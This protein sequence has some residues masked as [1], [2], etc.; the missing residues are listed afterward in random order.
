[1]LFACDFGLPAG[2]FDVE[3]ADGSTE[4]CERVFERLVGGDGVLFGTIIAAY[5]LFEQF[6]V[7]GECLVEYIVFELLLRFLRTQ[8]IVFE[9][10]FEGGRV[11]LMVAER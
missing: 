3:V 4:S 11:L 6:G 1:M 9:L 7:A 5:L 8:S 2:L 10:D